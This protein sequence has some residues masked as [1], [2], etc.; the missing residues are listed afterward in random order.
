MRGGAIAV[1]FMQRSYAEAAIVPWPTTR[2]PSIR[3]AVW[4][5]A[6]PSACSASDA[7][8]DVVT[9]GRSRHAARQRLGAVAQ[10]HAVDALRRRGSG[11]RPAATTVRAASALARDRRRPGSRPR[12]WRARTAARPAATP[13]PAALPDRVA[14]VAADGGRARARP[15]PRPRRD[16]SR[17]AAVAGEEALAL[18]PARKQ[19]SWLSRLS[20]TGKPAAARDLAH[21][22]LGEV[23]EREAHARERGGRAAR[24]ACRSGPCRGSAARASSGPSASCSI[25]A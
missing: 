12:R 17:R 20:A 15:R 7:V 23:A 3:Q 6:T 5:G 9:P 2:S 10:L 4:P 25:R 11:T 22:R 24:R 19:R 16:A 21:L 13:R 14:A 18:V 8:S 1:K